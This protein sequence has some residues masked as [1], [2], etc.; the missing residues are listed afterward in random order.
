MYRSR[1]S[2]HTPLRIWH[3]VDSGAFVSRIDIF[4]SVL[5]ILEINS[6]YSEYTSMEYMSELLHL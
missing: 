3:G 1:R 6:L 5:V 2:Y 4:E